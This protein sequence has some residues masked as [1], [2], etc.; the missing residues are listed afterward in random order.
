MRSP[1]FEVTTPAA[2][3]EARRLTTATAVQA[4]LFDGAETDTALIES[5]IDRVS[6]RAAKHCNLACDAIGTPPTFGRETCRATWP[7]LGGRGND[8][9][10]LPWRVPVTSITSVVEDGVTLEATQYQLRGGA[11]L[12][13]LDGDA[14]V[15]WSGRKIVVTYVTGWDLTEDEERPADIEAAIIDQVKAMYL[16]RDRDVTVRSEDVPGV[17]SASYSVAGGDSISSNGLLAHVEAALA[18]YRAPAIL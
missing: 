4:V 8:V 11:V 2:D 3:A 12:E 15:P 10:F 18:D 1:L 16:S 9:L 17:Y 13:R 6:A 5:M 14:L 7:V